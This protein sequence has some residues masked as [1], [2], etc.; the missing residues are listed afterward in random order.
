MVEATADGRTAD[1]LSARHAPHNNASS[2]PLVVSIDATQTLFTVDFATP[3]LVQFDII[4]DAFSKSPLIIGERLILRS[5][6]SIAFTL[7]AQT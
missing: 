6:N 2:S 4:S 3:R 7:N 5:R 1:L